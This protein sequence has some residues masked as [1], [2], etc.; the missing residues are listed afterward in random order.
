MSDEILA[1]QFET[2]REHLRAVGFRMLGSTVESDDAVQ[3]TWLKLSRSD[4]D[5]VENLGGWLTTVMSRVCLDMLRSRKARHEVTLD[6]PTEP[7]ARDS[8]SP[9][10]EDEAVLADSIGIAMMVVLEALNPAE[11]LTFVLHDMFGMPFDEIAPIVGRSPATTRQLASRARRRVRGTSADHSESR[12]PRRVVDA[13]LVAAREGRFDDLLEVL[14]PN[15][16][17]RADT[18]AVEGAKIGAAFGGPKIVAEVAGSVAVADAFQGRARGA[19]PATID[20][21]PGA[22]WAPGGIPRTVF[23]FT[24]VD[25]R[26]VALDVVGDPE[27]IGTLDVVL[28]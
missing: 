1:E 11:R 20:G 3:E 15:V 7:V 4:T 21:V 6:E 28:L 17:L 19:A 14:D 5:A 8:D 22:V 10:P 27:S 13:F 9:D 2:H 23:R 12:H 18:V 25:G 16:T 26:I 24:V